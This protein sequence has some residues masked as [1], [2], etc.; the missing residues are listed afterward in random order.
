MYN[1][2]T[3]ARYADLKRDGALELGVNST[4]RKRQY[5]RIP[6][7]E[8]FMAKVDKNKNGCWLWTAGTYGGG[9]GCFARDGVTPELA[10][11][12][13]YILFVGPLPK[14]MDLCHRCDTPACVNPEH[15][16]IGTR[17]DNMRDCV[18][19]GRTRSALTSEQIR[20]IRAARGQKSRDVAARYGLKSHKSIL[21]IWHG[22]TFAGVS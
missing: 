9:Y 18:Q 17:A 14:G 5:T 11:R 3:P 8:R 21:N 7:A 12:S 1:C 19:K 20:E 22:R 13:A 2:T 6:A 4:K 10:H 15:L 16:F